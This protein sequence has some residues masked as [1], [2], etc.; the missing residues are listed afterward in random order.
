M[1]QYF[2]RLLGAAAA[3]SGME[4]ISWL[5][6]GQKSLR[7]AAY[8]VNY[9]LFTSGYLILI[10]M[11]DYLIEYMHDIGEDKSYDKFTGARRNIYCLALIG[12]ILVLVNQFTGMIYW[13]DSNNVYHRGPLFLGAYL[14]EILI[15]TIFVSLVM[16]NRKLFG[17]DE[18][19]IT[20]AY[21][22]TPP[23]SCILQLVGFPLFNAGTTISVVLLYIG[24]H[25]RINAK[26][27]RQELELAEQKIVIMQSQIQPHFLC[28]TLLAIRELCDTNPKEAGEAVDEFSAYLRFNLEALND[29]KLQPFQELIRH[30]Q[31][32]LSLMQRRTDKNI[33]YRFDIRESDFFLPPLTLQPIVE[34]AVKHGLFPKEGGGEIVIYADREGDTFVISVKDN[35]VGFDT[36]KDQNDNRIHLGIVNVK[37]RLELRCSGTL[38]VDS[39][40]GEGTIVTLRIP[41]TT[42]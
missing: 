33:Q 20:V 9:F 24:M 13:I 28:N 7:L 18:A 26:L 11:T 2:L 30:T 1:N 8:V 16:R 36:S 12:M 37:K 39:K 19:V 42:K 22:I 17:A 40:P 5:V 10:A 38:Q 32:Y 34:N 27:T 25:S 6:D 4:G 31:A 3:I 41:V 21:L 15:W 14:L 35:G 29:K 23:L